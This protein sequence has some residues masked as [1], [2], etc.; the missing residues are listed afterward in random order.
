MTTTAITTDQAQPTV[1]LENPGF[2]FFFEV[3]GLECPSSVIMMLLS[4][5]RWLTPELAQPG[6]LERISTV[7]CQ[8]DTDTDTVYVLQK[9]AWR[10]CNI[11]GKG[12]ANG[13][14]WKRTE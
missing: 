9:G 10:Y 2:L 1:G 7:N 13:R 14:N 3:F 11:V 8:L 6:L 5:P 4:T 12:G